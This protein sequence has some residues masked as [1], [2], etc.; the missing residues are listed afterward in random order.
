VTAH[1]VFPK[2]DVGNYIMHRNFLYTIEL[3][4]V[5]LLDINGRTHTRAM[6]L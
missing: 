1:E 5:K 3:L 4:K 2:H 6:G